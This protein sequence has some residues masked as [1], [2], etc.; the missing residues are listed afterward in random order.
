M[1]AIYRAGWNGSLFI[2]DDNFIGNKRVLKDEVLPAIIEW[3]EARNHPFQLL[4][5]ASINLADDEELMTLMVKAGFDS[6][7]VGIE[8]PNE[9]S[10]AECAK[11]QNR[12]RDL[13]SAVKT[14][15]NK[16]MQV[17]GGFI[18][19]FDNDPVSI[20]RRQVEFIQKSGIVTAMVGL[21]NAP[22]GTRLHK[23]LKEEKR[24]VSTFSGDNTDCSM[25][26]VPR[27]DPHTL[28]DG[29]HHILHSIYNSRD[30][31]ARIRTFLDE[32]HPIQRPFKGFTFQDVRALFRS[33][34]LMGVID[35]GRKYYWKLVLDTL[36][37][38]PAL[39]HNTITLTVYGYHFRK[40]VAMY[41]RLPLPE[42]RSEV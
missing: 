39:F 1:D 11:T 8:T 41:T 34:W 40:I 23:R 35:R 16:G 37:R 31:Y 10:L 14:I 24:L 36:R 38:R 5:E 28:I 4:T 3:Q 22:P 15:Q 33:M 13:V 17:M 18:V 19:G 12:G 21:L 26:F 9:D 20:F 2:V 6:V 30:F 29:Y 42:P 7:F 32:F 25:N 27:M